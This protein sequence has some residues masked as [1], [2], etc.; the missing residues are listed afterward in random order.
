MTG[1][2]EEK[3]TTVSKSEGV[4]PPENPQNAAEESEGAHECA[5]PPCALDEVDP[6]YRGF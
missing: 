5:S 2:T 1:T 3:V 4:A 6:E